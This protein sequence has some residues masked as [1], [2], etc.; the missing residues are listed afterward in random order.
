MRCLW[1]KKK[2]NL[3]KT[4]IV[5]KKIQIK[6]CH[7][8]LCLNYT[9]LLLI[10]LGCFQLAY[11][12]TLGLWTTLTQFSTNTWHWRGDEMCASSSQS[13]VFSSSYPSVPL[14]ISCFHLLSFYIKRK[15][16]KR[17]KIDEQ[18]KWENPGL[19]QRYA[20]VPGIIFH[21]CHSQMQL[22]IIPHK[23]YKIK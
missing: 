4:K 10:F 14:Y 9:E 6:E 21:S 5:V 12:D 20:F 3:S 1:L 7:H 22:K 16:Q 2:T 15:E 23:V 8:C 11:D 18:E 17:L 13:K 19:Y